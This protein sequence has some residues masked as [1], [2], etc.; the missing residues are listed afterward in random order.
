MGFTV[1]AERD[2]N[3][4]N[5]IK[6][7]QKTMDGLDSYQVFEFGSGELGLFRLNL[8]DL[9]GIDTWQIDKLMN[10]AASSFLKEEG[11]NEMDPNLILIRLGRPDSTTA[12]P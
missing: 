2:D 6:V 10:K 3:V 8:Q 4:I 9:D 1:T 5:Q 11:A 12:T 7:V